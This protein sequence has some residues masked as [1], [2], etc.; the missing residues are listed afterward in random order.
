M[1]EHKGKPSGK[2]SETKEGIGRKGD[3]QRT[4]WPE[5]RIDGAGAGGAEPDANP[6]IRA[7]DRMPDASKCGDQRTRELNGRAPGDRGMC[8]QQSSTQGSE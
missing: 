8:E 6:Q 4:G 2:Y 3:Y 5:E 7:E 1:P